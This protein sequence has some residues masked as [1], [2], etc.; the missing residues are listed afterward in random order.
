MILQG[1]TDQKEVGSAKENGEMSSVNRAGHLSRPLLKRALIDRGL[2]EG[3]L[4]RHARVCANSSC[5][6]GFAGSGT[7]CRISLDGGWLF[8]GALAQHDFA[9]R[10]NGVD[11][12][13]R[14]S[15]E[16]LRAK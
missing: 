4:M 7:A 1:P 6:A 5:P 2:T 9:R 10:G 12:Q 15:A 14:R 13:S 8:A 3:S 11:C 16:A